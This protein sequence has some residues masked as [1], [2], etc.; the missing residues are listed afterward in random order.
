MEPTDGPRPAT[1]AE[2][3]DPIG[4]GRTAEVFARG[5][6]EVVKLL[7]PGVP[8]GLGELEA[9]VAALVGGAN[10]AAPRFLGTTRIEGRMGLL[11][12]RLV[13]PSMLDY[14]AR[15]VW[16]IDRQARQF[17]AL[18]AAMHAANGSGLPEQKVELRWMI[19]RAGA[20]LPAHARQLVLER[21]DALPSGGAICHG[22]MHPG[23]VL[24]TPRGAVVIDWPTASCGN[25]A[26][27]IARTLFL[28]RQSG[29]PTS[30]PWAQRSLI[31]LARRRFGSVYLRQY[32]H[33][34][35]LDPRD[36]A[37]WRLPVLAARL[38]EA[39]EAERTALQRLIQR[40]VESGAD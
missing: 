5:E 35:P 23:N 20:L 13:G 14:L 8:D 10:V 27:D 40:E 38:G 3:G 37:A 9:R 6:G 4:L 21:L 34:R 1:L 19:E 2:L 11:Y 12:E 25:P 28:L 30:L 15:R 29:V 16:E 18:H 39:I 7:R 26:G 33:L 22:D 31:A 17:A 24:L 36:V 32:Q